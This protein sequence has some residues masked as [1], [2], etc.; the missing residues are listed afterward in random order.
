MSF[1][2]DEQLQSFA[3]K[4]CIK[5]D[6]EM[7]SKIIKE[8]NIEYSYS[9][10]WKLL[11]YAVFLRQYE[12]VKLLLNVGANPNSINNNGRTPLHLAARYGYEEIVTRLIMTGADCS[13]IDFNGM[14]ALDRA[15]RYNQYDIVRLLYKISC[16]PNSNVAY[17]NYSIFYFV[18]R[19]VL[20]NDTD[21]VNKLYDDNI[22]MLEDFDTFFCTYTFNKSKDVSTTESI[23]LIQYSCIKGYTEVVKAFF[24]LLE[25]R[26]IKGQFD[27]DLISLAKYNSPEVYR[28]LMDEI[29]IDHEKDGLTIEE[30]FYDDEDIY[31][32]LKEIRASQEPSMEDDPM[33]MF[34]DHFGLRIRQIEAEIEY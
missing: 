19:A 4:S 3:L 10:E 14:S 18:K 24:K 5:H 22:I 28:L 25:E 29:N 13:I 32:E 12:I 9:K 6:I 23:N 27:W 26:E 11:H 7:L 31:N 8:I 30:Y 17:R 16:L 20:T 2:N 21:F 1:A 15:S 34:F 33:F